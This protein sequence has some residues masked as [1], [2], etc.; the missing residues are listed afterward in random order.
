MQRGT[1]S[2]VPASDE[3]FPLLYIVSPNRNSKY[4]LKETLFYRDS[5]KMTAQDWT[6][7]NLF[8]SVILIFQFPYSFFSPFVLLFMSTLKG[9]WCR[10]DS[11]LL[12]KLNVL[13]S[14]FLV[15][16]WKLLLWCANI[17]RSILTYCSSCFFATS[18]R[19]PTS[20]VNFC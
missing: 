15:M 20:N 10:W 13:N 7:L 19:K 16:R 11:W 2:H 14:F 3:S 9:R 12:I 1:K 17:S 18:C 4:T 6:C 8:L 5:R